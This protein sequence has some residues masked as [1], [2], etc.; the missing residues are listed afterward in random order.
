MGGGWVSGVEVMAAMAVTTP[1]RCIAY[2]S[3]QHR[4]A[5]CASSSCKREAREAIMVLF[6][7]VRNKLD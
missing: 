5:S 4:D 1:T 7:S 6:L 3:Q 2:G